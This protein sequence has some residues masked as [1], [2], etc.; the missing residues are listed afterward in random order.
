MAFLKALLSRRKDP[1]ET[2]RPLW[3]RVVEISREPH[4]YARDGVEDSV[5]GRFDMITAVLALLLLRMERDP[6]LAPLTHYLAELFVEDMDRQLREL[7]VGDLMVGKHI[8]KLMGSLG[9]RLAALRNIDKQEDAT[10]AEAVKRNITLAEGV[11]PAQLAASLRALD[12]TLAATP[13]DAIL[14]GRIAA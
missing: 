3:H 5:A 1:R 9:G 13:S 14:E 12:R 11:E 10:L 8:G 2:L 7:G 4:W 6:A